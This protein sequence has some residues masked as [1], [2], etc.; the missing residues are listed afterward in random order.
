MSPP[1]GKRQRISAS[2]Q[3]RQTILSPMPNMGAE[4][5]NPGSP[6]ATVGAEPI[7][8]GTSM[9]NIID[10]GPS[11]DSPAQ[12]SRKRPH[13]DDCAPHQ[14][15]IEQYNELLRCNQELQN[16]K[17]ALMSCCNRL[18]QE[19]I[20][21]TQSLREHEALQEGIYPEPPDVEPYITGQGY[22]FD[23]ARS[24]RGASTSLNTYSVGERVGDE[25]VNV[26][27]SREADNTVADNNNNNTTA[28]TAAM[29]NIDPML[30]Q[31][32]PS[33]ENKDNNGR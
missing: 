9:P 23:S 7:N 17:E 19:L 30:G 15:T 13:Q 18:L 14:P 2:Q 12:N 21:A 8:A 16:E 31:E 6:G 4:T 27:L 10:A 26:D 29:E 33:L 24:I 5:A 1:A 28:A 11:V 22:V 3:P 25:E 32:E 20:N